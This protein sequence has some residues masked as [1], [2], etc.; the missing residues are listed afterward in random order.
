M[1]RKILHISI[2]CA[3]AILSAGLLGGCTK[4]GLSE[5]PS[6]GPLKIHIEWP[7]QA[8][9]AG[10]QLLLYR[11]DGT[12]HANIEC[13][14]EGHECRVPADTYTIL[15]VNSDCSN[16]Q[17]LNYESH[18]T[19]HLC[20]ES[21]PTEKGVLQHVHNVYRTAEGGVEVKAGNRPSEVTLYPQNAVRRLR[22]DIDPAYVD[23]IRQ[24]RLRMSGVVPSIRL[25][26]GSDTQAETQRIL[27]DASA[28]ENGHYTADMS[29]FGWRGENLVTARLS[30]TD[31]REEVSLPQDIGEQLAALPQE[32]GTVHLTLELPSGGEIVLTVTVEAWTRGTGSATVI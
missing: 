5:R 27:A 26:D 8:D 7:D 20:A 6:D 30:Y 23:D 1:K 11:S 3:A 22:F 9:V 15:A 28:G 32:G 25:A 12:L 31:G 14:T 2:V 19:C 10:T 21:H 17:C 13:G 24:M 18:R 4:R 16:T 29:V